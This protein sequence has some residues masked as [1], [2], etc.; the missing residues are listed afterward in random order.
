MG[1]LLNRHRQIREQVTKSQ[2]LQTQLADARAAEEAR[3]QAR[4]AEAE[5]ELELLVGDE[6]EG[7][8]KVALTLGP[9]ETV[10]KAPLAPLTVEQ[11]L[12]LSEDDARKLA[13]DSGI[14]VG[15]QWKLN[16]LRNA[17]AK[18]HGLTVK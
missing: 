4:A 8:V 11:L 16:G 17:L 5:V 1:M 18:L 6:P 14:K 13:I 15:E 2:A 10:D 12:A 3:Q 9:D 7:G